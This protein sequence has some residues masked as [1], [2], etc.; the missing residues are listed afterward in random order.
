MYKRKAIKIIN[1][2]LVGSPYLTNS[3]RESFQT[4]NWYALSL[5]VCILH[6]R[7]TSVPNG[8]YQS[9]RDL[10]RE[11]VLNALLVWCPSVMVGIRK[12]VLNYL[13]V[14]SRSA[15]LFLVWSL[16]LMFVIIK[17][18]SKGST[19]FGRDPLMVCI[20]KKLLKVILVLLSTSHGLYQ[21]KSYKT[22]Y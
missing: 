10:I 11:N 7:T 5:M 9:K 19:G 8:L 12:K 2:L 22:L 3:I 20:R 6:G 18:S 1:A 15:K 13:M 21:K 14:W 17:K 16:F 4:P